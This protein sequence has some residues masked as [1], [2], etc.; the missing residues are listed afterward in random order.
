MKW[1]PTNCW[2]SPMTINGNRHFQV[3][4]YGGK[5][6]TRWVELFPIKDK[7][8]ILKIS[9]ESLKLNWTSGWSR[10]PKD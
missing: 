5:S 9:W 4:A 7:K 8:N 3:K 6:D 10:L 1:P 2:T